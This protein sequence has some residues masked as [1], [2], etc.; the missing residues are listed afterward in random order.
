MF[1]TLVG[2]KKGVTPN[3]VDGVEVG[4]IGG[5]P[6]CGNPLQGCDLRRDQSDAV[7]AEDN[8]IWHIYV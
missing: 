4:R 3:P 5:K 6:G 7:R 8:G 1:Q 2:R